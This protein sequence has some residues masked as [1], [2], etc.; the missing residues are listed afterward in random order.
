MRRV[1]QESLEGDVA[2]LFSMRFIKQRFFLDKP[3]L[4]IDPL[5]TSVHF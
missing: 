4:S 2:P 5:L 1:K 3:I